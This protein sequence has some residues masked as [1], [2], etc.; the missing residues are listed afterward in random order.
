MRVSEKRQWERRGLLTCSLARSQ[1]AT[2]S[3][4]RNLRALSLR[5]IWFHFRA[6]PTI[7]QSSQFTHSHP[8]RFLFIFKW[9]Q[10]S[11]STMNKLYWMNFVPWCISH[12]VIVDSIPFSGFIISKHLLS[13]FVCL[14]EIDEGVFADGCRSH[15]LPTASN[16][17]REI[18]GPPPPS[19]YHVSL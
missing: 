9:N 8:V 5:V 4:V 19:F 11:E 18:T 7:S 16:A 15:F 2:Y 3:S 17:D 10:R 1:V 6:I 13:E 14:V 12:D